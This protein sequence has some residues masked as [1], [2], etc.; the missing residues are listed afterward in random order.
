MARRKKRK[1]SSTAIYWFL[2]LIITGVAAWQY[3][4]HLKVPWVSETVFEVSPSNSVPQPGIAAATQAVS[5]VKTSNSPPP[6]VVRQEEEPFTARRVRNVLEAQVALARR[7]I[8]GGPIDGAMGSQTRSAIDAFQRAE[9]ILPTGQLDADT[10]DRL[11]L[12]AAPS[13]NYT[14]TSADLS[15]LAPIG[16][17]WLS[18]SEQDRLEHETILELVAEKFAAHQNLIRKLNPQITWT[19]IMAGTV[20]TVPNFE[21]PVIYTKAAFIR[22]ELTNK[23]LEAYDSK[24]NLLVH[25][26]CSIARRVEKRPFGTLFVAVVARNP[27][28]TWNPE[29]YPDSEEARTIARKLIIPP[30]PNNP[31]GTAWIGLDRPGYGI[32]GTPAPEKVG[33][34]E[35]LGC[36]RLANWNA[37]TLVNIVQIGT[38]VYVEP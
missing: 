14:I 8:S 2:A 16:P 23:I 10:K 27:N 28:Y 12:S 36:F 9:D 32:H 1:G 24:T 37:E 35:S 7:G 31:V 17:T 38:P 21:T 29:L 33:R 15:R 25:F 6:V 3:R 30:G 20:V 19:N 13:K 26:P 34:S 5:I 11:W 18:K 22:I 4:E